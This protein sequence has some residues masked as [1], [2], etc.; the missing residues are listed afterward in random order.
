MIR[1]IL[2]VLVWTLALIL[3]A[4]ASLSVLTVWLVRWRRRVNKI[5]KADY[6]Q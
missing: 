1:V 3:L 5:A 2:W 6:W 4:V